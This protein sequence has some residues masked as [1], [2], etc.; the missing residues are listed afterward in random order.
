MQKEHWVVSLLHLVFFPLEEEEEQKLVCCRNLYDRISGT[1]SLQV[2]RYRG[3]SVSAVVSHLWKVTDRQRLSTYITPWSE[4]RDAALYSPDRASIGCA[5]EC[6]VFSSKVTL[7]GSE[8]PSQLM[9]TWLQS[10]ASIRGRLFE[11]PLMSIS[12]SKLHWLD[13]P[14]RPETKP[15]LLESSFS[16]NSDPSTWRS[17]GPG[18]ERKHRERE[19]ARERDDRYT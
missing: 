5:V 7:V 12:P 8:L 10:S 3:F 4:R 14:C 13:L 19:R 11:W 2:Q 1:G 18:L 17:S 9:E 6:R 15:S 16:L